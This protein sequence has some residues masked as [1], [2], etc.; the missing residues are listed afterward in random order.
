MIFFACLNVI[1]S[2]IMVVINCMLNLKDGHLAKL[3]Y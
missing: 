1:V 3:T 2:L